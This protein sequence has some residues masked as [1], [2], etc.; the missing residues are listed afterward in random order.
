MFISGSINSG[1][2]YPAFSTIKSIYDESTIVLWD[3]PGFG[4]TKGITQ[5]LIN[6]YFIHRLFSLQPQVKLVFTIN[7]DDIK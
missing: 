5:I 3:T 4:D 2:V 7:F 6:T 1:T